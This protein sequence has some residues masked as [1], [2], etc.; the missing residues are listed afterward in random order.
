MHLSNNRKIS[1]CEVLHSNFYLFLFHSTRLW[2]TLMLTVWLEAFVC[3]HMLV[4]VWFC[5]YFWD[6]TSGF[7]YELVSSYDWTG[8][9]WLFWGHIWHLSLGE[10]TNSENQEVLEGN[11]ETHHAPTIHPSSFIH[12][13]VHPD[14][15]ILK[16][17]QRKS[18]SEC[19]KV[20][21]MWKPLLIPSHHPRLMVQGCFCRVLLRGE[22][23]YQ[24]RAD[25]KIL[26]ES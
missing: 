2:Y 10:R 12:P 18:L 24:P 23:L 21:R 15:G 7:L 16:I 11:Q 5:L 14:H 19:E 8:R 1:S 20:V 3:P 17:R 6:K 25:C 4:L 22:G 9:I 13:S 26:S